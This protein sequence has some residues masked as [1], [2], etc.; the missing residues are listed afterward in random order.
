MRVKW[1]SLSGQELIRVGEALPSS[2]AGRRGGTFTCSGT[3]RRLALL[4]ALRERNRFSTGY[5]GPLG[6]E[7]GM[8]P[9]LLQVRAA[10]DWMI[11]M[12]FGNPMPGLG[13]GV[14]SGLKC[15][16]STSGALAT[17]VQGHPNSGLA[18]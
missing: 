5:E 3:I 13:N 2:V 4:G 11:N 14:V 6:Q 16:T 12:E 18:A 10:W 17:P 1:I 8:G 15:G 9:E 7:S